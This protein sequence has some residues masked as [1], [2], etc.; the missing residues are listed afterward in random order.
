M[1]WNER[2]RLDGCLIEDE[3]DVSRE[4]RCGEDDM[5]RDESHSVDSSEE[6]CPID[7]RHSRPRE[8]SVCHNAYQCTRAR[9]HGMSISHGDTVDDREL[10]LIF[11]SVNTEYTLGKCRTSRKGKAN[12]EQ[13]TCQP[14][15]S[16]SRVARRSC[17]AWPSDPAPVIRMRA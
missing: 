4:V 13:D 11:I 14:G 15:Q 10:H 3:T 1:D 12:H 5:A 6:L 16:E 9:Y 17:P 2:D 8:A 7:L